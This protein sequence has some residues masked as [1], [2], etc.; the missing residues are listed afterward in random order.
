MNL[1]HKIRKIT[2]IRRLPSNEVLDQVSKGNKFIIVNEDF[3][4]NL[5]PQGYTL[6]NMKYK[7]ESF[8]TL[9]PQSL[10]FFMA[11]PGE[12]DSDQALEQIAD[13]YGEA[14]DYEDELIERLIKEQSKKS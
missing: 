2:V 1:E 14:E 4:P 5:V 13:F 11:N 9:V 3:D 10:L 7:N 8:R 6:I 12:G